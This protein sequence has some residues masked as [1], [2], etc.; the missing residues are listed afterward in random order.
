MFGVGPWELIIILAI[1]LLLFGAGRL[2]T[3]MG[4][5]AK[6]VKAFKQGLKEEDES[7]KSKQEE[8]TKRLEHLN[9]EKTASSDIS[10]VNKS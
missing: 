2:P 3:L 1:V 4:D 6:G 8:E 10:N 7:Q 9:A 5:V